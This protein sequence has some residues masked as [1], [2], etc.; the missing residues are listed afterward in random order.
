MSWVPPQ[1]AAREETRAAIATFSAE[2]LS[3][4]KGAAAILDGVQ[5]E[6]ANA[7]AQA[8]A[9]ALYLFLQTNEGIVKARPHVRAALFNLRHAADWER[10]TVAA[11]AAWADGDTGRALDLHTRIARFWPKDLVNAKLAQIHQLNRGDRIGMRDLALR[12]QGANHDNGYAWGLVAFGLEQAGNAVAAEVAGRR[13][14]EL[15]PDDAWAHHAVAH[16]MADAG[17]VAEGLDWM[18]AHAPYWDRCSSFMYTHNWWHTALLYLDCDDNAGAL[19]LFDERVWGVR[20]TYVQDQVNAVALL[21][22]LELRGVDVGASRW[23]D[24]ADH[25]QPRSHDHVNGFLDLHYAY[26]L[27]RAGDDGALDAMLAELQRPRI[28]RDSQL[29]TQVLPMAVRGLTDHARGRFASA[30][31]ALGAV[32]R[33]LPSLGGSTAQHEWFEQLLIDSLVRAG[34][35]ARARAVLAPRVARQQPVGW[36]RRLLANLEAAC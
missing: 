19:R 26:A 21:S 6:P 17:R 34:A 22:R 16:V 31:T 3:H 27:A 11:I 2:L 25:V 10:C 8:Y 14:V 1:F 35:P 29:W 15:Q 28:G 12:V 23:R 24:V 4:G 7:V 30:A 9:A 13:A 18:S 36:R 20:K 32:S 5:A 33:F